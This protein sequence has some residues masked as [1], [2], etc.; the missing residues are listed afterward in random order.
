MGTQPEQCPGSGHQKQTSGDGGYQN[1]P[2]SN[3]SDVPYTWFA[4][5][6]SCLQVASRGESALVWPKLGLTRNNP[7]PVDTQ[8]DFLIFCVEARAISRM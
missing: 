7:P 6:N 3:N 8:G 4:P 1:E 2:D 5:R